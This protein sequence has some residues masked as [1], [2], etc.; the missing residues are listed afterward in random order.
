MIRQVTPG[1]PANVEATAAQIY[2]PDLFGPDFRR[3]SDTPRTQAL[4]YGYAVLRGIVCR[5]L[6]ASGLHPG[7][8]LHHSVSGN[9]F[10]LADDVIEPFRPIVDRIV[11]RLG[12]PMPSLPELK[13]AMAAVG[14][15]ACIVGGKTLRCRAAVQAA[16]ASLVR[17]VDDGSGRLD[18]PEGLAES[19]DA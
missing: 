13:A 8:G 10:A 11:L 17:V 9:P 7:L 19:P 2:W 1:D 14:E 12:E 6:V 5:S 4:D 16:V 3:R 18:L 15:A